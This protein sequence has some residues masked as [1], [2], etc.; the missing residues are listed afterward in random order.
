M[1]SCP[2]SYFSH[3]RCEKKLDCGRNGAV[4][5]YTIGQNARQSDAPLCRGPAPICAGILLR[6][7]AKLRFYPLKPV[8][9]I[10]LQKWCRG[11]VRGFIPGL[12]WIPILIQAEFQS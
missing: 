11:E 8:A 10:Q 2:L 12:I 1:V 5:R 4:D 6:L 9:P 7:P 3:G